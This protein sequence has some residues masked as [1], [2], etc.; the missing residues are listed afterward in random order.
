VSASSYGLVVAGWLAGALLL[1]RVR[2]PVEPVVAGLAASVSVVIPARDEERNLPRLLAS[3]DGQVEPPLEVLVVD[4]G[5]VDR[6]A[7]LARAAGVGVVE[8]GPPPPGWLGKPWAC[9]QGVTAASGDVL[10]LLDADTWLAPD[11]VARL[12]ASH[13]ALAA[14]GL[15][16]VQP[17]HHVERPYEELSAV[18]N[19]VPILASGMAA[20]GR[21]R[22]AVVAFGPCLVTRADALR[23]VGGFEAVRAEIVEDAALARAYRG[24]GRPVACLGGGSTVAFR[25]Y[26]D[27][28]GTLVEGWTKNLAG[29]AARV[30][31]VALLGAVLW[32]AAGLSVALD[33]VTDP[34]VPVA[35]AWAAIAAQLWWMLHRLGTFHWLTAVLFPIPLIAFV[36]LF[37]RSLVLRLAHR[38]VT[39]RGRRIDP[40][41]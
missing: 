31:P 6:T 39:W 28:I 22:P 26:P 35:L 33:A 10:L 15:L 13:R 32:V 5:S 27:G 24:D 8:A 41:P 4:D 16:S 1:W 12:V 17:F 36:A 23:R 25:M 37:S 7:S 11:G 40:R 20:P 9:Q 30:A 14:D 2:T 18:C 38:P 29:G 34:T 19:V 3:L 21:P